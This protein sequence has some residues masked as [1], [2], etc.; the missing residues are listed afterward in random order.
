VQSDVTALASQPQLVLWQKNH[1]TNEVQLAHY[2]RA[3]DPYDIDFRHLARWCAASVGRSP[4]GVVGTALFYTPS[5]TA[6]ALPVLPQQADS[7][8]PQTCRMQAL[9]YQASGDLDI[10]EIVRTLSKRWGVPNG[11]P[12][13]PDIGGSGWWKKIT[14]WHREGTLIWVAYDPSGK[15]GGNRAPRVVIVARREMAPDPDTNLQFLPPGFTT[16]LLDAAGRLAGEDPEMTTAMI[17]QSQCLRP[18]FKPQA[19]DVAMKRITRWLAAARDLPAERKSA[20]YLIADANLGCVFSPSKRFIQAVGAEFKGGCP[21]DGPAYSHNYRREAGKINPRGAGGELAR[22]SRMANPCELE[23]SRPWPD[24][25][26]EMGEQLLTQFPDDQWSPW[27]HYALGRAH[28]V[29]LSFS[30]PE[31][32]PEEWAHIPPLSRERKKSEREQAIRH[33]RQFVEERR[34][35]SES[36]FAWQ[37]AWRL[38]AGLPPTMVAFGCGC[39]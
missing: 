30:F 36:V 25:A 39:E 35:L 3:R 21:Q 24:L 23:G 38:L 8:L 16:Q 9:W 34:D 4:E 14:A 1:R 32:N 33:L 31:G 17:K 37:E 10:D 12:G 29:K 18:G 7:T 15:P 20:A 19:E 5:V 28:A 6:G 27:L 11:A 13:K 22:L 2:Q 26:I